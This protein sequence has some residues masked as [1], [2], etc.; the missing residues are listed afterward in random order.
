VPGE[1]FLYVNDAVT[2]IPDG[3]SSMAIT[4]AVLRFL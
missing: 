3:S 2:P 1:L 4:G